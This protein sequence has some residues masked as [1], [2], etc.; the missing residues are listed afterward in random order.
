MIAFAALAWTMD[1]I[2]AKAPKP[3]VVGA[4]SDRACLMAEY[5]FTLAADRYHVSVDVAAPFRYAA[6]YPVQARF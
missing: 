5:V 4:K 6:Q 2:P 3:D 1:G